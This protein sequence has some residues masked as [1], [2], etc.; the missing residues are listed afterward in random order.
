MIYRR[1][2]SPLHAARAAAG[3][4]WCLALACAAFTAEHPLVLGAVGAIA[5]AA[6]AAAGVWREVVRAALWALPIAL[7]WALINPFVVRDGLTVIAR[8]GNVPPFGYVDLTLEAVVYGAVTGLRIVVALACF[9]LLT[10]AVDPDRL[11]RLF[12]RI[13]FRSALAAALATRLLPVLARDAQRLNDARRC[14]AGAG[15]TGRAG[16]VAVVRALATGALDRALD[17]AATLE[18]RGYGAAHRSVYAR[19]PWSRHDV[20][21]AASAAAMVALAVGARAGGVAGF[22]YY[23][24]LSAAPLA[25]HAV[26]ALALGIIALAPFGDRRGIEP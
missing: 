17:V 21:F 3:G 24:T 10:A 7:L 15:A 20:A 16:N 11:L 19:E 9:A 4:A 13:S 22:G 26:L 8:V 23:P 5:L 18:V 14:R 12:R 2:A 6:A 25:E 1:R